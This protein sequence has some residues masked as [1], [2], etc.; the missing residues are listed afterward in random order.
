MTL[1]DQYKFRTFVIFIEGL[2]LFVSTIHY[3][4][5]HACMHKKLNFGILVTKVSWRKVFNTPSVA[6][7]EGNLKE[8]QLHIYI[9]INI[10]HQCHFVHACM[11]HACLPINAAM[12][13]KPIW[14]Q[15]VMPIKMPH[16]IW[17][18][19]NQPLML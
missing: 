11:W 13:R 6:W 1:W 14:L 19:N 15:F 8:V 18:L 16:L 10:S 9:G 17:A 7:R 4:G 12:Y 5:S 3:Y 2:S